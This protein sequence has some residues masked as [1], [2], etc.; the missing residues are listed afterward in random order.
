[1]KYSHHDCMPSASIYNRMTWSQ[2]NCHFKVY[3][4]SSC[5]NSAILRPFQLTADKEGY[6]FEND[7]FLEISSVTLS[8]HYLFNHSILTSDS[9]WPWS[10]HPPPPSCNLSFLTI[11]RGPQRGVV[12]I[13]SVSWYF[14]RG[15]IYFRIVKPV[16]N[17]SA[18]NWLVHIFWFE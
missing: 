7:I 13:R 1:M 5:G 3:G 4:I 17:R 15:M 8:P 6:I 2:L 9:P 10:I 12:W 14:K 16:F 18:S 11:N